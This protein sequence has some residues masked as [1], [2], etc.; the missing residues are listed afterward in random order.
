M[1]KKGQLSM[2]TAGL[3]RPAQIVGFVAAVI[4]LVG[5]NF[6]APTELLPLAARNTLGVL[7]AVIILLVT[8]TF[9]LGV[10]CLLAIAMMYFLGCVESVPGALSGFTNATLFFVLASFG[11]S[12]AITVVPL[13]KRLLLFL[14]KKA[15]KDTN[16]LM[17][18]IMVV[19]GLLSS[20]LPQLQYSSLLCLISLRFT[21]MMRTRREQEGL[22]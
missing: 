13:S 14:M 21:T 1:E 9:P 18:A 3:I 8:E 10:V 7:L 15:G 12:E 6:V 2:A 16:Q 17:L 19:T 20:M 5:M 22:T 11:I 4:I